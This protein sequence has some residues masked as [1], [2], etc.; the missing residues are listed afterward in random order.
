MEKIIIENFGPLKHCEMDVQDFIVLI[1]EQASGKS[2]IAKCIYY[3]K[4]LRDNLTEV[5][6]EAVQKQDGSGLFTRFLRIAR[7]CFLD[8]F[9]STLSIEPFKI[10]YYYDADKSVTISL[11][12]NKKRVDHKFSRILENDIK[13]LI[14]DAEN[15]C[16]EINQPEFMGDQNKLLFAFAT[17]TKA[18][19]I[20]DN[21]NTAFNDQRKYLYIPAGR[22]VITTLAGSLEKLYAMIEGSDILIKKFMDEMIEFKK[23]FTD[24]EKVLHVKE[25]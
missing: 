16:K 8:L 24:L 9:G 20:I 13:R 2:T 11:E 17:K 4:A 23:Y 18:E 19:S 14:K 15:F 10:T 25:E 7:K 22:S 6:I 21:I 3:C 5:L 12:E 1:G